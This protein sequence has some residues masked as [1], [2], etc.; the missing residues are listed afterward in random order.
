MNIQKHYQNQKE[1]EKTYSIFTHPKV[2]TRLKSYPNQLSGGEQQRVAIARAIINK[3]KILLLDEPFS[4]LDY[5]T[6]LSVSDDVYQII[7]NE[8]NC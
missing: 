4:A 7:K 6:R 8:N 1:V 3:P 5:Q 2:K